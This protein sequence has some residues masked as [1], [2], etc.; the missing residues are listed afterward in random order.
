MSQTSASRTRESDLYATGVNVFSML[1]CTAKWEDGL[2]S[3][4]APIRRLT[5]VCL[6]GQK[7]FSVYANIVH[8]RQT[9]HCWSHAIT[10]L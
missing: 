10:R 1:L 3:S 2:L 7:H 8:R 6:P 9:L 4:D 5:S